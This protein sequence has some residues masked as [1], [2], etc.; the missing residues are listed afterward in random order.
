[1]T[2]DTHFAATALMSVIGLMAVVGTIGTIGA[3]WSLGRQNERK[4]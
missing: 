4:D 3:F 1:M 2:L